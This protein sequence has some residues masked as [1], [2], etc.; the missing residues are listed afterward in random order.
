MG[1]R[2]VPQSGGTKPGPGN[3]CKKAPI[4]IGLREVP[5]AGGRQLLQEGANINWVAQG[6][7][8][9]GHEAFD[10]QLLQEG[11][12]INWVARGAAGGG[13]LGSQAA[14]LRFL[15]SVSEKNRKHMVKAL[16]RLAPPIHINRSLLKRVDRM[17]EL[18][19]NGFSYRLARLRT[20]HVKSGPNAQDNEN[21]PPQ[22]N[23]AALLLLTAFVYCKDPAIHQLSGDNE[24]VELPKEVWCMIFDYVF[25][26]KLSASETEALAFLT[27]RLIAYKGIKNHENTLWFFQGDK[28]NRAKNFEKKVVEST[29]IDTFLGVMNNN[30]SHQ[31]LPLAGIATLW[32][33]NLRKT[34][35]QLKDN[36]DAENDTP[37]SLPAATTCLASD[38]I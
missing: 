24:V 33:E 28:K 13:H 14:Q 3:Y 22:S 2:T 38:C 34:A 12:D 1:L 27:I 30:P 35:P 29:N 11:A 6:A 32:V 21:A 7:A 26:T 4:L 20:E 10:R 37:Q 8:Y 23:N 16:S 17:T 18:R 9:G 31:D 36:D 5:Q 25:E 15:S 19:K